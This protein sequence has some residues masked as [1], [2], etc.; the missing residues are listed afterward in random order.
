LSEPANTGERIHANA[1]VGSIEDRLLLAFHLATYEWAAARTRG[2]DVLDFGCGTGYGV[3]VIAPTSHTVTAIDVDVESIAFARTAFPVDNVTYL[4]IRPVEDEDLPFADATFDAVLSFQVLEHVPDP[5]RYLSECRR[6]LKPGKPLYLATPNRDA[7]LFWFQR[8][9]NG[10]HLREYSRS[11]LEKELTRHFVNVELYGMTAERDWIE[12]ETRRVRRIRWQM[13]PWT[14]PLGSDRLRRAALRW[15]MALKTRAK[16]H[17]TRS[18]SESG[19]V[20]AP[21]DSIR[22]ETQSTSRH[23][24]LLAIARRESTIDTAS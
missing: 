8:P 12:I 4:A 9:W 23:P 14:L 21:S 22:I 20:G 18:V 7:R 2:G 6:V 13:L 1:Q 10:F 11:A 5:E 16:G 15:M 17:P 19:P 3:Q 24:N